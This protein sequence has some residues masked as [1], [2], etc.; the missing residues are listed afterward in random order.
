VQGVTMTPLLRNL[1]VLS[2]S[3][4]IPDPH[5]KELKEET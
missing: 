4:T 5:R 1:K 2:S 3:P